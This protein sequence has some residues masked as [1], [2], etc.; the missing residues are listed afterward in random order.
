MSPTTIFRRGPAV[1]LL[2]GAFVACA[3]GSA[4]AAPSVSMTMY[5]PTVTGNIGAPTSG[6]SVTATLLRDGTAVATS[7]PATTGA[8]GAWTATLPGHAPSSSTDVVEVD[9]AGTGAPAGNARYPLTNFDQSE[10]EELFGGFA[11]SATVTADGGTVS[12]YCGT[13]VTPTIPVHL[14]YSDGSSQDV[15]AQDSGHGTSVANI[16]PAI[17]IG[18]IVTYTG[19]F[20]VNDLG[21]LP[22]TLALTARAN[23]PGEYAPT[24]CT[25]NV[26]TG[27]AQCL[28]QPDGSYDL[29]RVRAGSPDL[30]ET[31]T[32]SSDSL[33]TAFPD[34][35]PG[36]QL[37]LRAHDA[38][39]AIATVHLA[40]LRID[41]AQ[42]MGP[43]PFGPP[44]TVTGG[45]C[46]PG[47]RLQLS[48]FNF[49]AGLCPADG[50]LPVNTGPFDFAV[51][52]QD[53]LGPG[54]TTASPATFIDTSP[55]D[56]EN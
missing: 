16:T 20:A 1:A 45:N 11:E 22:T 46:A 42:N 53:D 25:G 27:A 49:P 14:A 15:S 9:Y 52:L 50:A 51:R 7:P 24:A 37:A 48:F 39:V 56:G 54:G 13:C 28:D 55:L 6:V 26:S 47:A 8:D 44:L 21:G 29:V 32:S 33:A 43:F 36:D 38:A 35:L 18:D 3:A 31:T 40:T 19:T 2:A 17:G 4:Q 34:L 12:I 10:Q 23:L 30:T 41:A 5:A